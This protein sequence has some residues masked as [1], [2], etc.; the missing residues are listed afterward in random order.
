MRIMRY[1]KIL[2]LVICLLVAVAPVYAQV[3]GKEV[4]AHISTWGGLGF[5]GAGIAIV[6]YSPPEESAF[7]AVEIAYGASLIGAGMYSFLVGGIPFFAG[8]VDAFAIANTIAGA[9]IAGIALIGPPLLYL[10]VPITFILDT[11]SIVGPVTDYRNSMS[12]GLIDLI[13]GINLGE[14]WHGNSV[15]WAATLPAIVWLLGTGITG[16]TLGGGRIVAATAEEPV[17][18]PVLSPSYI[19]LSIQY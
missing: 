7:G 5:G 13:G 14:V 4:L 12:K 15:M 16:L 3:N 11:I 8:D 17:L 6:T 9:T 10:L 2:L 18:T 19:G 1:F